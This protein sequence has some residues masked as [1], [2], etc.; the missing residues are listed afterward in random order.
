MR[1]ERFTVPIFGW[2]VTFA[3]ASSNFD[4]SKLEKYFNIIQLSKEDV[5][6][7]K[8]NKDNE[9][10]GVHFYNSNIMESLIIIYKC[11]TEL[12]R[13]NVIAHEKRHLEDRILKHLSIKDIETAAFISGYLAEKIY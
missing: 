1:I 2:S 13:K 9:G 7:I 3:D 11:N 8:N 4:I 5:E 6:D 10:G 12:K